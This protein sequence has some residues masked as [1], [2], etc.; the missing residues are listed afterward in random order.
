MTHIILE[1]EHLNEVHGIKCYNRQI[2]RTIIIRF[3]EFQKIPKDRWDT[4]DRY[5]L[6]LVKLGC[7]QRRSKDDFLWTKP[8]SQEAIMAVKSTNPQQNRI[9]KVDLTDSSSL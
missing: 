3:V 9:K 6:R 8:E 7:L 2:L 4:V 5:I 1:L